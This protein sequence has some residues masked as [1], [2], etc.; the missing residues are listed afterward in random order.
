MYVSMCIYERESAR[1]RAFA[2]LY[3]C[4]VGRRRLCMHVCI[5]ACNCTRP[6]PLVISYPPV[7][8]AAKA[9]LCEAAP[10]LQ[11]QRAVGATGT[12]YVC[13]M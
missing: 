8:E 10:E 9:R 12:L 4:V 1:K 6:T 11:H 13:V 2:W 5:Y 7:G 3:V